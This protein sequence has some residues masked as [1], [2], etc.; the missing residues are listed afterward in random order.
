MIKSYWVSKIR[1][2]KILHVSL[3]EN[4][5]SLCTHSLEVK[6]EGDTAQS[7][8]T[9]AVDLIAADGLRVTSSSGADTGT[10]K[11][12]AVDPNGSREPLS[13]ETKAVEDASGAK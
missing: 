3:E 7:N 6:R 12:S 9:G 11:R 2:Q 4:I 8:C 5:G 13:T 1:T 10:I